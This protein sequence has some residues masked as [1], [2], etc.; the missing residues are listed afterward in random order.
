MK[1]KEIA[2]ALSANRVVKISKKKKIPTELFWETLRKCEEEVKT[3]PAWKR[4]IKLY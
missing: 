1:A 3:W 2:K 4:N